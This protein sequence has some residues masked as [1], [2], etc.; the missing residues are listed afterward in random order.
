MAA[1]AL[2]LRSLCPQGGRNKRRGESAM[3]VRPRIA[4]PRAAS[5][6]AIAFASF[7]Q[8]P[9]DRAEILL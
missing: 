3:H 7:A 8:V 2:A 1:F 5:A 4:L 9:P 6:A